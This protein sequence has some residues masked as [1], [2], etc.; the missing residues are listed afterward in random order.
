MLQ[1]ELIRYRSRSNS[2]VSVVEFAKY[3]NWDEV[4][5]LNS[6]PIKQY[7]RF[8]P[9]LLL[10]EFLQRSWIVFMTDDTWIQFN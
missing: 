3:I 1:R 10:V 2:N 6:Q 9:K 8:L 5:T 7:L 4:K